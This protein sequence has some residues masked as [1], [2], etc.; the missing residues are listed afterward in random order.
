M[1]ISWSKV[2]GLKVFVTKAQ[3]E[4]GDHVS[5]EVFANILSE[6]RF[7]KLILEISGF[8]AICYKSPPRRCLTDEEGLAPRSVMAKEKKELFKSRAV[9]F[10]PADGGLPPGR[11]RFPFLFVLPRDLPGS[12][13]VAGADVGVD[14][15]GEYTAEVKYVISAEC[16]D[17]IIL[18]EDVQAAA[19]GAPGDPAGAPVAAGAPGD[20]A[21]APVAA[22]A[23]EDSAGSPAAAGAPRDSAREAAAGAAGGAQ[24]GE[25]AGREEERWR[26]PLKLADSL[27]LFVLESHRPKAPPHFVDQTV[28][29]RRCLPCMRPH[30]VVAALLLNNTVVFD[31]DMFGV[32]VE[33]ENP[34]RHTVSEVVL[35]V[36][37]ITT[38]RAS[39]QRPYVVRNRMLY[40]RVNPIPPGHIY[41]ED[42]ALRVNI[43]IPSELQQTVKAALFD[44]DYEVALTA[45]FEKAAINVRDGVVIVKRTLSQA[46]YLKAFKAP[47]DWQHVNMSDTLIRIHVEGAPAP[48]IGNFEG[49]GFVRPP[50]AKPDTD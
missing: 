9:L 50:K 38:L 31:G 3:Y 6:I 18:V 46:Q 16:E 22:V 30:S 49:I 41:K 35:A 14:E 19:A 43:K 1:G 36:W 21:G 44:V 24:P 7:S 34:S 2:T 33:V 40:Q 39:G 42:Y 11:Y 45:E 48:D 15:A 29:S 32:N 8:E 26:F 25:P 17:C 12:A 23:P 27:E 37:R 20:S 10:E 13:S 5:G 4:A 47:Y 28:Q